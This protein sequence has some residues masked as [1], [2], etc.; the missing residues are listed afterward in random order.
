MNPFFRWSQT[1][2]VACAFAFLGACE[3]SSSAR[4]Q[5]DRAAFESL[6]ASLPS[7][8]VVRV[9]LERMDRT[10][11][12][13]ICYD[14]GSR[15]WYEYR[16]NYGAAYLGAAETHIA[17]SPDNLRAWLSSRRGNPYAERYVFPFIWLRDIVDNPTCIERF[18]PIEPGGYELVFRAP[19]GDPRIPATGSPP[20]QLQ[21]YRLVLDLQFCPIT[22]ERAGTTDRDLYRRLATIG[23]NLPVTTIRDGEWSV[24]ESDFEPR[25]PGALSPI[26]RE[27]IDQ[28][29]RDARLWESQRRVA[30]AAPLPPAALPG[31]AQPGGPVAPAGTW[32]LARPLVLAG[33][34]VLLCAGYFWWRAR[35]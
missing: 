27:M 11:R 34:F 8:G 13:I 10:E 3:L 15:T 28:V 21:G 32:W 35:A 2:R 20:E 6:R 14:I 31:T 12:E 19:L 4:A 26:T 17:F 5:I 25:S 18:S 29:T 23:Q 16:L 9:D 22:V 33:V 24:R 7:H 30:A 1:R